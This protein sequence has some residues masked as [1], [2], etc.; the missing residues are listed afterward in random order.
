MPDPSEL[1]KHN[2]EAHFF[3]YYKN[4]NVNENYRFI[5]N[6]VDFKTSERGRT[7]GT[8]TNYDS[9]DDH[10]DDL[11]YYMQYIKF[12]FGRAI[13]DLSRQIQ[14]G[15]ISRDKALEL[16]KRYDGEYPEDTIESVCKFLDINEQTLT[17][18]I[19]SHRNPKVWHKDGSTWVNKVH[20]ILF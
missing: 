20:E 7:Y 16:A 11:Y 12:G 19:D 18:I 9:L 14:N 5:S 4:W 15:E 3:G 2:I 17:E 8:C 13:R 1:E 6:K 10:M